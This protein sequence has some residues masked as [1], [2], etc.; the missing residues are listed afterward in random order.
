MILGIEE[1]ERRVW[2]EEKLFLMKQVGTPRLAAGAPSGGDVTFPAATGLEGN[3][4]IF[5]GTILA[6]NTV[7]F[8]GG[9][10]VEGR[11]L[12]GADL[13]DVPP[14]PDNT[15]TGGAV[16]TTAGSTGPVT[17]TLPL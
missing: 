5:V 6:G 9:T 7:T 11:V 12:A 1:I 14:S 8:A 15:Q 13:L 17:V 16:T 10:A 3:N 4:T 2:E